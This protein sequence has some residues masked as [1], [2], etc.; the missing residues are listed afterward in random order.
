[1]TEILKLPSR[2]AR[3][4]DAA[5]LPPARSA[6]IGRGEAAPA[7]G[8]PTDLVEIIGD[9]FDELQKRFLRN[10]SVFGGILYEQLLLAI[11]ADACSCEEGV[12]PCAYLVSAAEGGMWNSMVKWEPEPID[13]LMQIPHPGSVSEVGAFLDRIATSL[14]AMPPSPNTSRVQGKSLNSAG[15]GH[16]P[17]PWAGL[18]SP[19][20][21]D[22]LALKSTRKGERCTARGPTGSP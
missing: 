15:R 10:H 21:V 16:E 6:A 12:H 4:A 18:R 7:D 5:S 22:F 1:M 2:H 11:A 17:E 8:V 14:M 20:L 19:A 9:Y 13:E 3:R